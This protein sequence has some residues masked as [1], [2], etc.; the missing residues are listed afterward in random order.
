MKLLSIVSRRGLGRLAATGLG[1][2]ALIVAAATVPQK[3]EAQ[4]VGGTLKLAF[5]HEAGSFD[6][7]KATLGM[8]HAIIEQVYSGLTALDANANP[9]PDLA[10][11]ID[12][13][14]DGLVYTF[15]LKKGVVFHDGTP[16]TAEDVKYTFD[17]LRDPDIAYPYVIQLTTIQEVVV[18]GTHTVQFR[19]SEPTGP[20]LVALAFP[21]TTIISKKIAESGHDLNATPIGTGPFKFVSYQLGTVIKLER[22]SDYYEG[23][24]PF[25]GALEYHI[26]S[27]Q[28]ALT[29]ALQSGIVDFSNVIPAKDWTAIEANPELTK[30]PIEG[31]R[32][33]LLMLNN[34]SP[35]LDNPLVRQAIAHAIDRQAIV[36]AWPPDSV[37]PMS[38]GMVSYPCGRVRMN[39]SA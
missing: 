28:T 8:S 4:Q 34:Q 20:L 37:L 1:L 7:A 38:P 15:N 36:D 39:S 6:P 2:G 19:L 14:D 35:P 29:D 26:I 16:F 33:F 25:I 23:N 32:W 22:N 30:V 17:R 3:A 10:A 21:G 9:Y 27:D 5:D 11:T 31:G 13:S 24:K 18:L 12:V